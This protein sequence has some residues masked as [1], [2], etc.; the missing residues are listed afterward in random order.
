MESSL[1]YA[2]VV[3]GG[4][5]GMFETQFFHPS[6]SETDWLLNYFEDSYSPMIPGG[7]DEAPASHAQEYLRRDLV[8]S[9]LYALYSQSTMRVA[10]QTLTTYE[11]RS[12][13]K[14]RTMELTGSAAGYWMRNFTEMLC[15]TVGEELW[16][17]QAIPR[18]WLNDGER[19]EMKNL[20]TEFGPVSYSVES[21]LRSGSV[22]AHVTIPRRQ[23]V[24]G[25][26]IRFRVPEGREMQ[27]VLMN[28]EHWRDFDAEGEWV[29]VPATFK[30]VMI[31]VRY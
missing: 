23:P 14:L 24:K 17:L 10:R 6:S 19:I 11:T 16:L 29:T 8:G 9:F 30:E 5:E 25:L 1:W 28:G 26:K 20:Q 13:G 21:K 15:R 31:Q 27:S 18:R 7:A 2:E 3:D 12:Q 22:E 4:W